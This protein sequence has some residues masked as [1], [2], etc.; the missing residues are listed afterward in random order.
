M[1]E[2]RQEGHRYGRVSWRLQTPT[3]GVPAHLPLCPALC[4]AAQWLITRTLASCWVKPKDRDTKTIVFLLGTELRV[5]EP[6]G[7]G[8][9]M[10]FRKAGLPPPACFPSCKAC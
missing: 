2:E 4:R 7:Q 9:T 1:C 3:G 5:L 6:S 10:R 8:L